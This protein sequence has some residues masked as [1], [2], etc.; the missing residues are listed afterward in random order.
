MKNL[1]YLLVFAAAAVVSPLGSLAGESAASSP[2]SAA[3]AASA[4][5]PDEAA[6][7]IKR[8]MPKYPSTAVQT[9]GRAHVMVEIDESGKVVS[10]QI[11]SATAPQFGESARTAA[12]RWEFKP[13]LKDGQPVR[14]W[15]RLP[16]KFEA[17][18]VA[19]R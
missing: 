6:V 12:R 13:A 14:S 16:F 2:E 5:Q 3:V 11:V 7:P 15:T 1:R 19:M 8:V 9:G 18:S 17:P 4:N 10:V